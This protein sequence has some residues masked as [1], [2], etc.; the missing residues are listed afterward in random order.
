MEYRV[1]ELTARARI[2]AEWEEP[3]W[4]DVPALS[5]GNCMGGKPAHMPDTGAKIAWRAGELFVIFRVE[6]RY[7]RATAQRD[8]ESVCGDSC[9]EFFF[10]PGA[11]V[12]AGYF[13][14]EMNCGGTMLFHFQKARG[15]GRA[16]IAEKDCRRIERAHSLPGK[17][18]PEITDPVTWTVE[19]ALPADILEKYCEVDRPAPGI[20]WRGNFYKCGDNTS[21]PHWLTWVRVGRPK[22]DFHV[23]G[24][25]GVLKFAGKAES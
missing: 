19:Y 12:S 4:E 2:D 18:E 13:N 10:T 16:V 9:V 11:D 21:H 23:P 17:V 3:V 7:V 5:I 25:F 14:I 15:E 6:D 20:V 8:Q 1:T 22:P 24:S